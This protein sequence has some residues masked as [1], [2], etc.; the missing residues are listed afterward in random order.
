[1]A[2]A[3]DRPRRLRCS[4]CLLPV[5]LRITAVLLGAMLVTGTY[6]CLLAALPV[7]ISAAEGVGSVVANGALAAV[8]S[9]QESEKSEDLDHPGEDQMDREDR[10]E[11]LQLDAP[12]VIEL[13]QS[14]AGAPEYRELQLSASV[15]KAQWVPVV[16]QDTNPGGWRPAVHFLQ[17][18]FTPPLGSPARCGQR[19]YCL[20]SDAVRRVVRPGRRVHPLNRQFRQNRR[21]F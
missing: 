1:M 18:N 10:C 19:L 8:A 5:L 3:K 15:G 11:Q 17:M 7:A 20:S 9:H 16:G 13:H 21:N 2:R 14:A 6:G 12:S 4:D